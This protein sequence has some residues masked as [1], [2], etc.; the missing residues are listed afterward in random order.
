VVNRIGGFYAFILSRAPNVSLSVVART[1]YEVVKQQ[2]SYQL[3]TSRHT[4]TSRQGLTI[5]SHNHGTH[6]VH[7]DAGMSCISLVCFAIGAM[8]TRRLANAVQLA[9][10]I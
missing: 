8:Q 6:Q 5:E 1:N 2:V 4:F 3:I 10:E 7:F 9:I